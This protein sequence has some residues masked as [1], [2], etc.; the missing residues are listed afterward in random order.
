M[1]GGLPGVIRLRERPPTHLVPCHSSML[2]FGPSVVA[3]QVNAASS[4]VHSASAAVTIRP[5]LFNV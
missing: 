5:A 3:A 2:A 1:S 4:L